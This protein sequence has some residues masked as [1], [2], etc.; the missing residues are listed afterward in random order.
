MLSQDR[1]ALSP[2]QLEK[3]RAASRAHYA[4]NREAVK[5]QHAAYYARNAAKVIER[6]RVYQRLRYAT[7]AEWRAREL[8]RQRVIRARRREA[9]G[10]A[11]RAVAA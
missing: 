6:Q 1:S 8:E 4:R 11:V 3:R 7:D 5:A 9:A 2:E 10:A